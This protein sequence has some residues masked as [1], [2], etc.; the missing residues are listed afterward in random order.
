LLIA[1]PPAKAEII[2][3]KLRKAKIT[4]TIIG[5]VVKQAEHKITIR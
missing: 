2:V 5:K 4:A 1:L 3:Q